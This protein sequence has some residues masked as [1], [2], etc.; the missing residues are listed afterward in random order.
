M[1]IIKLLILAA[2]PIT[3]LSL[4]AQTDNTPQKGDFTVAATIGYNSYAKINAPEGTA[5]DYEVQALS[6]D[7]TDKKLMVGFEAGWFFKDLWK[8]SLGGGFNSSHGPGHTSVPG[9]IDDTNR[10]N[11]VEENMGEIPNYR[12]VASTQT[13]SYDVVAGID[14]YHNM[15]SVKNMMW[16]FGLRV[17]FNYAESEAKYDEETSMGKS[18][19]EAWNL[20]GAIAFGIDYYVLPSMFVGAS[21]DPVSYTYCMTSLKPQPGLSRLSSDSHNIG[22]MAAPTIKIGFR[23]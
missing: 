11:S 4:H 12:A 9:T 2:M 21:I 8:L 6:T 19:A 10:D 1:K 7:W 13:L 14:R 5:T 17:G 16:Y 15:P 23:F 18:V 20:R 22:V 3:C